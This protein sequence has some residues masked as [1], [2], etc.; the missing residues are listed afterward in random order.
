MQ[1]EDDG[2]VAQTPGLRMTPRPYSRGRWAV[3]KERFQI[4]GDPPSEAHQSALGDVLPD[5]LKSLRLDGDFW[6]QKLA[7]EWPQVVGDQVARRSRPGQLQKQTL[8]V[9]VENSV[10]LSELSRFAQKQILENVQR[11]ADGSRI[12]SIRLQLDPE[13]VGRR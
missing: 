7:Q 2:A 8:V 3:E 6:L 12:R 10:W 4:V 5:V 1:D 13:R 11:H 9:F